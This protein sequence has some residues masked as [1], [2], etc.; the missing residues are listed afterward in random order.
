MLKRLTGIATLQVFAKLTTHFTKVHTR[1]CAD[2]AE[3]ADHVVG[4]TINLAKCRFR[5]KLTPIS[6]NANECNVPKDTVDRDLIL[7]NTWL[8]ALVAI[9][10]VQ[11]RF[12]IA[13]WKKYPT[14]KSLLSVYIDPTKSVLEKESL[15]KDLMTEGPLGNEEQRV[16]E[17]CSKRIY[18]IFMAQNGHIN[19]DEVENDA[20]YFTTNLN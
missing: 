8:K 13:V 1:Q 17:I 2:E 9:P 12:A 6:V 3:L 11:P 10:K 19:T 14:M 18:R 16:G 7:K 4:L 15:L 5:K 20:E